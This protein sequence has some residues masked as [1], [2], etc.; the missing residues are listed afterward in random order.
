LFNCAF[1]AGVSACSTPQLN[2]RF[3]NEYNRRDGIMAHISTHPVRPNEDIEADIENIIVHYPPLMNDRRYI[4]V[5]AEDGIVSLSG[6]V[7]T[8]MNRDYLISHVSQ[9]EGVKS[10]NADGLFDDETLRLEVGKFIPFGVFAR[11]E[12]GRVVLSGTLPKDTTAET[13][14]QNILLKIPGVQKVVT[15]LN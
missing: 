2:S 3:N 13:I 4:Q 15:A 11:V 5:K 8:P 12:Y 7:K 6:H 14:V 1:D 10:V 9:V